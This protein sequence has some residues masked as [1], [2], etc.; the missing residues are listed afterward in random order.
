LQIAELD[1]RRARGRRLAAL[2]LSTTLGKKRKS[3]TIDC[4]RFT[5]LQRNASSSSSKSV[6]ATA[7]A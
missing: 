5:D 4:L 3:A 6:S 1:E 2:P 7:L